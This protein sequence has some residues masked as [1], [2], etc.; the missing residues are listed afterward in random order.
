MRKEKERE[1]GCCQWRRG[2]STY[3]GTAI[4]CFYFDKMNFVSGFWRRDKRNQKNKKKREENKNI[5][6]FSFTLIKKSVSNCNIK[7][8]ENKKKDLFLNGNANNGL[9]QGIYVDFHIMFSIFYF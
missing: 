7:G 5:N 4:L 6:I 9:P 3:E 1:R 2:V 8:N